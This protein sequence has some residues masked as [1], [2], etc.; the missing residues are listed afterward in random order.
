MFVTSINT[1]K[2][3]DNMYQNVLYYLF[4]QID[5]PELLRDEHRL[6][7]K[8]LNLKG[9]IIFA[10]EG[11]NGN[12]S[13][14][15]KETNQYMA[16]L[17][18]RFP[19]IEFKIGNTPEH[20]Y[21]K[22]KV[23]VRDEIITLKQ[24]VDMT[25]RGEYIT[26]EELRK[27]LDAGE[28]IV[29]FDGRNEYEAQF[30]TFKGAIVPTVKTFKEFP[31]FIKEN[32]ADKKDKEIVTFCTGGIRCEKLSAYMK[33]EGFSKVKQLHGGILT[34]GEEEEGKHWDGECFVFDERLAVDM[35]NVK[36]VHHNRENTARHNPVYSK[37]H[38]QAN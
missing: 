34:Y 18:A 20:N 10:K 9:K 22:M 6:I 3:T 11:I 36:A 8:A 24:E 7:T 5:N 23:T 38:I 1:T 31:E 16:L 29:L 21:N 4:T 17:K 27:K 33:Q 25:N 12:V 2:I 19:E 14:T 30:G 28:D 35:K 15:R 37:Q 13:G 32:L 26:P